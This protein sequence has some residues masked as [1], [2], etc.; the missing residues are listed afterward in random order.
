MTELATFDNNMATTYT[1]GDD[2]EQEIIDKTRGEVQDVTDEVE[3]SS[4]ED[5]MEDKLAGRVVIKKHYL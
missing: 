2:W 4:D 5:D 3:E 1:I